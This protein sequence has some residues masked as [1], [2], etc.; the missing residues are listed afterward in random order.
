MGGLDIRLE[1][2]QRLGR[3]PRVDVRGRSDVTLFR[4]LFEVDP[5][6]VL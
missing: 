6:E 1:G 2:I 3:V 4:K 5:L